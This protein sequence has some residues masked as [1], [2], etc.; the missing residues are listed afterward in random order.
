MK[1]NL[2]ITALFLITLFSI[3]GV[4]QTMGSL[5]GKVTLQ[6]ANVAVR[7]ALITINGLRRTALTDDAGSFEF[8]G[9]PFGKYEVIVHLERVSDVVK[10]VEILSG[11]TALDFEMM[12][13][14]V[15]EQVTVT[16]TGEKEGIFSSFQPVTSIGSLQLT[17]KNPI[18]LGEALE[19]ESG[20][21]K[22]SFSPGASRPVIR[23]FD[24]DR[25]LVM[26]DGLRLGTVASQSGAYGE[27][28]NVLSVDRI[29]VV[30]GAATLL[31]GSNAIGG[32]INAVNENDSLTKGFSGYFTGFG[33]SNN[34][35]AGGNGGLK[36]GAKD[37]MVWANGGG[38]KSNDYQTPRGRV[39]NSFS[40]DGVFNG[41][42]GWFPTKGF[43][44]FTYNNDWRRYGIPLEPD[45]DEAI[46]LK[47]RR[48][49][50]IVKGG[51]N[52][53][54]F[55]ERGNFAIQYNEFTQDELEREDGEQELESRFF[56]K[57]FVYRASFEQRRRGKL[58]GMF[59]FSG[60]TR[61]YEVRGD[62]DLA[63][64]TKQNNF[65]VF[66]LEKLDFK[67]FG[68]QFGG[69]VENTSYKPLGR[70]LPERSF[71]GASAS[72]GIRVPIRAFSVFAANFTH[73]FRAP[74]LEELYNFGP[75]D[76]NFAFERGNANL[77]SE[78]GNGLDLSYRVNAK[79]V[80]AEA[81]FFYYD[82]SRFVFL[83]FTGGTDAQSSLPIAD[84]AQS[85]SRFVGTE[86][87]FEGDLSRNFKF[88]TSLDY[89]NAKL[90]GNG[91]S[92]PRI[93]PLRGKI[94]LSANWKN[95]FLRPEI[96]LVNRQDKI[97][98]NETPTSGYAVLNLTGSYTLARERSAQIFSFN[99]YNLTDKFYQNHLSLI[100]DRMPEI[101][102]GVR[103]SY[104]VRFF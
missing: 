51:Y 19:N 14:V 5:R 73:S 21:A 54:S 98:T 37:F 48:H 81:N 10:T 15:N 27:S 99:A 49:S 39:V 2:Y 100:K 31:Y 33:G 70:N 38:Q 79:R 35:Q 36:F 53:N 11:E 24:G 9:I 23:G 97:Y 41:G 50:Y 58:S 47:L 26:Q 60:F 77:R 61:D 69:R 93:P 80:R 91:K 43:L 104:T 94:G 25:V 12:L 59:G 95:L 67:T 71:T 17:Q 63:P 3:H 29:E 42:A 103:F 76:D 4:G 89:V 1:V 92:L 83:A 22:R 90:T 30:K 7:G 8:Q 87:K 56:N 45:E 20:I 55:I 88:D 72:F 66:A 86:F 68:L 102:R 84:Y 18:S 52:F 75:H 101:G 78:I 28:L 82:L 74:A 13:T 32:V 64:H 57:T 16:V 85:D 65:A 34:W 44:S 40:R 6:P 46:D 96:L 62:D